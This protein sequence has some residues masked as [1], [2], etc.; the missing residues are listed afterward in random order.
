MQLRDLVELHAWRCREHLK[1]ARFHGIKI[2]PEDL[3]LKS[4]QS[5]T[6]DGRTLVRNSVM[7][8]PSSG[9]IIDL[10]DHLSGPLDNKRFIFPSTKVE[11]KT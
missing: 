10:L 1:D 8:W 7:P 11:N 5:R 4:S 2:R 3:R 6:V 9:R